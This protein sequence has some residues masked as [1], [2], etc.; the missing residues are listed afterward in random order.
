MNFTLTTE[1]I[2]YARFKISKFNLKDIYIRIGL[3]GSGCSGF[4][5]FINYE[6]TPIKEKD[7]IFTF[8]DIKVVID[9]KS[10]NYLNNCILDFEK[11]LLKRGFKFINPNEKSS[12][13]CGESVEF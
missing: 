1:A 10:M 2:K 8:D 4:S 7:Y 3:K 12:C 13:S 9:K 6:N 5:Y 11:N